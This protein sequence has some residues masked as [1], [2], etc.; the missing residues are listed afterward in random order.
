MAYSLAGERP[1]IAAWPS[2]LIAA[3]LRRVARAAKA[4]RQRLALAA[5]LEMD[6][7]RLWDLGISRSDL[8][9]ALRSDDFDLDAIRD[10][11]RGFDLWPPR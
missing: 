7:S 2:V 8:S 5:L 10:R 6:D 4:R 1:N 11:R 9:R 3:V